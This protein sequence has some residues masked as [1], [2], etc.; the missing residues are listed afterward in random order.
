MSSPA[1]EAFLALLY[2][3]PVVRERFLHDPAGEAA[4]AGL[5]AEDVLALR[6]IDRIGLRMASA[7]Y[8]RKRE[9]RGRPRRSLRGFLL[10]CWRNLHKV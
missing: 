4:L 2:T 1:L 7:S 10:Q 8:A 3:D 6:E 5:G 9:A